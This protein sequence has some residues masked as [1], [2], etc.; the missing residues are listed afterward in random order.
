M[1]WSKLV[2]N[3]M[4]CT[5][6]WC[7]RMRCHVLWHSVI[8]CDERGCWDPVPVAVER[9][10][11]AIAADDEGSSIAFL[12]MVT[13]VIDRI[14]WKGGS[15]NDAYKRLYD[16]RSRLMS[17]SITRHEPP[18]LSSLVHSQLPSHPYLLMDKQ[19]LRPGLN[20]RS[21]EELHPVGW[22]LSNDM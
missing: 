3:T 10:A 13:D 7:N 15:D 9:N 1:W 20:I 11:T 14:L 18:H 2:C 19:H 4:R 17:N 16:Q 5:V 22:T 8:A 6:T 12:K 21:S